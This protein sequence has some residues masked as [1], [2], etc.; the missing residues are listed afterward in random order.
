MNPWLILTRP[1]AQA[2]GFLAALDHDGPLVIS[3]V[4][5]IV[6]T[7]PVP[8]LSAYAGLIL[9][10]ANAAGLVPGLA[11]RTVHCVG[12]R[13]A[14]TVRAAGAEIGRVAHDA[15]D[16]VAQLVARPG[17]AGPLLHLHGQHSRG[18]IADRLNS[19][20]IETDEAVIYDQSPLP[21]SPEA[22]ALIEGEEPV[23][24]PVFSPR[25]ARLLR[26]AVSRVGPRVVVVAIS[27]AAGAAWGPATGHDLRIC[28]APTGEEMQAEVARALRE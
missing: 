3:P 26:A 17:T 5:K 27:P 28:A 22:V 9:T 4:M 24:L 11:G 23:V 18:A 20:G 25:S 1:E 10:S 21:L 6:A 2:R 7:G 13:T 12:A 19:A 8:D 14:E 15:D 16:L